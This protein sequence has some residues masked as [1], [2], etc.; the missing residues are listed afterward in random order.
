MPPD[1]LVIK[2]A[3][4]PC[5]QMHLGLSDLKRSP[6]VLWMQASLHSTCQTL[7]RAIQAGTS[8]YATDC[9]CGVCGTA[10]WLR[11]LIVHQTGV[12]TCCI[13]M[14]LLDLKW[15]LRP[16]FPATFHMQEAL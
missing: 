4:V 2:S 12:Q 13:C 5:T 16:I 11:L 3:M 1:R 14:F 10:A 6:N 7:C 9:K 8:R 15:H